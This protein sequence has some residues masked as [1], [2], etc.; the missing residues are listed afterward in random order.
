MSRIQNYTKQRDAKS[1]D[2]KAISR[3]IT[4]EMGKKEFNSNKIFEWLDKACVDNSF[5]RN[6]ANTYSMLKNG[7]VVDQEFTK[8]FRA[9]TDDEKTKM[10]VDAIAVDTDGGISQGKYATYLKAF[11]E[12][13]VIEDQAERIAKFESL[14]QKNYDVAT[15]DYLETTVLPL[16]EGLT[17]TSPLLSRVSFITDV[18]YKK[19]I[20]FDGEKDAELLAKGA[21]GTEADDVT[22]VSV[23]LDT[24]GK[25]IQA[26]TTIN[27]QDLQNLDGGEWAKFVWRLQNRVTFMLEKQVLY[28]SGAAT[29]FTRG[30]KNTAGSTYADKI[31]ALTV[32]VTGGSDE[33]AKLQ[34]MNK[35]L[36]KYT[37]A[38]EEA[39]Y[40]YAVD[41]VLIE[42]LRENKDLNGLYR[43]PYGTPIV[44]AGHQIINS[45]AVTTGDA[46]LSPFAFYTIITRG[47]GV[48]LL[49]DGGVVELKEGNIIYVARIYAD[50]APR[51]AFKQT[52]LG[53][54]DNNQSQN[55]HRYATGL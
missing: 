6:F 34:L 14:T 23:T 5:R 7:G 29:Q 21:A 20:E 4:K 18:N 52:V 50:G 41:R 24:S 9:L 42:K 39:M 48:S 53:S 22:R 16:L 40:V 13:G 1:L 55:Y 35:D 43:F 3:E 12:A 26:S 37:S 15:G 31:G 8:K 27:E 25:K 33:T 10:K 32:T 45:P 28:G 19:L 11:K 36:S 17:R 44:I 51:K 54:T 49:N 30:L 46:F 38:E 2:L 47:N